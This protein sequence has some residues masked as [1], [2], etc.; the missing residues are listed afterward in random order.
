[1]FL[2]ARSGRI[3][4]TNNAFS[5]NFATSSSH[6]ATGGG[7]EVETLAGGDITLMD[8][9]FAD[10]S[11]SATDVVGAIDL[12]VGGGARI[13]ALSPCILENDAGDCVIRGEAGNI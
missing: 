13:L 7:A 6:G 10:N 3:T 9:I 5:N 12:S 1:A 11:V 2:Q 8:N 4:L